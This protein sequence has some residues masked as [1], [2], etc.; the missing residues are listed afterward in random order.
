MKASFLEALFD[1]PN[2]SGPYSR[3]ECQNFTTAANEL[4][5]FPDARVV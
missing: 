2:H 1:F 3:L 5:G 4:S